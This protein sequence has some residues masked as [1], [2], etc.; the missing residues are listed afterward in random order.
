MNVA[1]LKRGAGVIDK[2][3]GIGGRGVQKKRECVERL[4]FD[5]QLQRE[6]AQLGLGGGAGEV[7]DACG[8]MPFE[9]RGEGD[10]ANL[11]VVAG[12]GQRHE[13]RDVRG[14]A[15]AAEVFDSV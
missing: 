6:A 7:L 5:E 1:H 13:L 2:G 8:L 15:V 12:S 9:E 10:P 11:E 4:R 14:G 3:V